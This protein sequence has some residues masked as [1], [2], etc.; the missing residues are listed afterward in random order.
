MTI[1][2]HVD[3]YQ[4]PNYIRAKKTR[5]SIEVQVWLNKDYPDGE[6]DGDWEMPKALGLSTAIAQ[7]VLQTKP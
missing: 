2:F 5:S 3:E 7:A 1:K 6:P 4:K